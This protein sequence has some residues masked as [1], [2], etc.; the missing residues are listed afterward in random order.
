[1]KTVKAGIP[2]FI[3]ALLLPFAWMVLLGET[4][5]TPI[6]E[7][8]HFENMS[9]EQIS[10]W[11]KQNSTKAPFWEHTKSVGNAV[12]SDIPSYLKSSFL[13]FVVVFSINWV[14]FNVRGKP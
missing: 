11:I 1:M 3:I 12:I 10:S 9:Q 7:K 14:L 6:V 5:A 8:S 13:V 2:A 4:N